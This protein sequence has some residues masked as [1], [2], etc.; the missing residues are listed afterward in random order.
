LFQK[1]IYIYA[2]GIK[3]FELKYRMRSMMLKEYVYIFAMILEV[4]TFG[5]QSVCEYNQ[6]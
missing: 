6:V 1:F 3:I 5:S 2:V 4:A